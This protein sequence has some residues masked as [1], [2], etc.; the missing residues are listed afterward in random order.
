MHATLFQHDSTTHLAEHLLELSKAEDAARA[1][2]F[3]NTD[4]RDRERMQ[5]EAGM[6]YF[7]KLDTLR[8]LHQHYE[9]DAGHV[10]LLTTIVRAVAAVESI[11]LS[12][13]D[14]VGDEQ[15]KLYRTWCEKLQRALIHY[16]AHQ[17]LVHHGSP[18][19]GPERCECDWCQAVAHWHQT[20][21]SATRAATPV[22]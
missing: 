11:R 3:S 7:A 8:A 4:P 5:M 2:L 22:M 1:A 6:L 17:I 14:T 13:R 12:P 10:P 21:P 15:A 20:P 19:P 16:H 9:P 18:V